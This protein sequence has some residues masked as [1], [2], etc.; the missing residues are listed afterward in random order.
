M[1]TVI[2]KA[3]FA[4]VQ[5]DL[6]T[7]AEPLHIR[8][9]DEHDGGHPMRSLRGARE[10]AP[11][12]REVDVLL[13]GH[14]YAQGG[15][16]Q[17]VVRLAIVN[18]GGTLLSKSVRVYGDR[19]SADA[20]PE[21][22]TCVKLSF[23]HAFGGIG[24]SDNP[25]GTGWGDCA[26]K[27]PNLVYP[28][29]P[30]RTAIFG[31][32]P[33]S[34]PSRKKLLGKVKRAVLDQAVAEIPADLDWGYFQCSPADQRIDAIRGGEW[35]L[36]EH[37]HPRQPLIRSRLPTMRAI[38]KVY[39]HDAVGAPDQVPLVIDMIHIEPDVRRC[40]LVWRGSFP[41]LNEG[42][43]SQL[44]IAGALASPGQQ[45]PW[46]SDAAE[47]ADVASP[48]P[49]A[50][51]GGLGLPGVDERGVAT[52]HARSD[53]EDHSSTMLVDP[54]AVMDVAGSLPFRAITAAPTGPH[55]DGHGALPFTAPR[56]LEAPQA[57]GEQESPFEGTFAL[58]PDQL[59]N[60]TGPTSPFA[61]AAPGDAGPESA[62]APTIPGAPWA[63]P[64][65]QEVAQVEAD[66]RAR[67]E[68]EETARAE[69]EAQE[70]A[71]AEAAK[72]QEAAAVA[73]EQAEARRLAEAERFRAEQQEAQKKAER[74]RKAKAEEKREASKQLHGSM[75]GGFKRN[76]R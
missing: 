53:G 64:P 51:S 46:P 1:V 30:T 65:T 76:K 44:L 11:Q 6:A 26:D 8:T 54:S 16:N 25:L 61:I 32:I 12:L 36:L 57:D 70:R 9:K 31:P 24:H 52:T 14:A 20:E 67:I 74:R 28:D 63:R 10:T 55:D 34:F 41:V 58:S 73:H 4:L 23:E 49:S 45:I 33:A 40:S 69:A 48:L 43:L 35:L 29:D 21:P 19:A 22:F 2:V 3:S 71:E 7:V 37:F 60:L 39:G 17:T 56:P 68:A 75:Y 15:S 42:A 62:N 59:A 66:E 27:P 72:Q 18:E 50:P 13:T 5:D 38:A 47:L